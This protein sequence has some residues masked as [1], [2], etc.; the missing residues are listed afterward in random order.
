ML[1]IGV[2]VV[3]VGAWEAYV[4]LGG[5]DDLVL[6]AP[7]QIA[8]ALWD[9]RGLLWSNFTVTAGEVA[10]GI[11]ISIVAGLLFAVAIHFSRTLRRALEP[12]LGGS[13]RTPIGSV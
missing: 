3:I 2:I 4:D 8:T 7:S 9:D 5:V 6:A 11:A 13:E 10:L 1:A 12:P